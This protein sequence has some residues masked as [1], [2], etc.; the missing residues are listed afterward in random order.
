MTAIAEN[1]HRHEAIRRGA[2]ILDDI[3]AATAYAPTAQALPSLPLAQ[4]LDRAQA[5]LVPSM[6]HGGGEYPLDALGPLAEPALDLANGAQ[7]ASGMAG[8]SLLAAAALLVQSTANVRSLDGSSRP[9]SLYCLTIANSGDGKDSADRPALRMIHDHQRQAGPKWEA[10][11]ATFEEAK[12]NRKKNEHP[13]DPPGSAPYRLASD[14][15]I[16]G[17]RRSFAEGVAV[18]CSF[19]SSQLFL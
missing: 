4:A 7:V 11:R 5:M 1:D 8:Q 18:T 14:L 2:A 12:A 13:P 9:L 3:A 10:D 19:F 16:E 6:G 15:T 17:L